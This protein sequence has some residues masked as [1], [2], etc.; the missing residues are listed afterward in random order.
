MAR[1]ALTL[2]T[3]MKAPRIVP[4]LNL[5]NEDQETGP[6]SIQPGKLIKHLHSHAL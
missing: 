3:K 1:A 6:R 2:G 4:D 5:L